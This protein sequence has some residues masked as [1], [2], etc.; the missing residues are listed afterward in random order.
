MDT[1][2]REQL[3]MLTAIIINHPE[4]IPIL[5]A[6][7]KYN[8]KKVDKINTKAFSNTYVYGVGERNGKP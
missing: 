2:Q 6:Y 5:Q 4:L 3:E 8:S 1:K 7:P